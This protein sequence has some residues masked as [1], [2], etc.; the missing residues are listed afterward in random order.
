MV[1]ESL[2]RE[3][4]VKSGFRSAPDQDPPFLLPGNA[5]GRAHDTSPRVPVNVVV[6][7]VSG[8][9]EGVNQ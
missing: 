7:V 6:K 1:N 2:C 3:E 4:V 9:S 5:A 8:T